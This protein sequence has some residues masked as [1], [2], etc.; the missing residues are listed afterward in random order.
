MLPQLFLPLT[1]RKSPIEALFVAN[2]VN[3]T[4]IETMQEP[5]ISKT[6]RKGRCRYM[7]ATSRAISEKIENI[8]SCKARVLLL[9]NLLVTAYTPILSVVNWLKKKTDVGHIL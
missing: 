3:M 6:R 4:P 7:T 8:E 1:E 9:F 5:P 2:E